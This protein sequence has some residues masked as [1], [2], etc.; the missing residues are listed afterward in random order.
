VLRDGIAVVHEPCVLHHSL[1]LLLVRRRA[2]D[3]AIVELAKA[4]EL[5]PDVA[6]FTHVYAVALHSVGRTRDALRV[7]ED[8]Q[9][10]A[11][12]DPEIAAALAS[13]RDN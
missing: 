8:A 12:H 6:R 3:E 9:R 2:L 11:P 10:R 7:L 1:G 5:E 4:V 13:I